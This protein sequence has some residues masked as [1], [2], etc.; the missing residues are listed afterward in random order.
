MSGRKR[1]YVAE[2]DWN[3]LQADARKLAQVNRD[4]PKLVDQLRTQTERDLAHS[5]AE[6]EA[7]HDRFET[8][9]TDLSDATRAAE[10][11]TARRLRDTSS[12]ILSRVRDQHARLRGETAAALRKDRETW[13]RELAD[14]RARRT[15][16]LAELDRKVTALAD[17]R[18]RAARLTE[19][20]L[21][22]AAILRAQVAEL[23]HERYLPGKLAELD[24]K[25]RS[26]QAD[27]D[28]GGLDAFLLANAR[29]FCQ[30]MGALRSELVLLDTEWRA[31][32]IAAETELL[33]L[34]GVI[35]GN[36]TL[37][38]EIIFET[39]EAVARPDVDYWS[40]GALKRLAAEVTTL[41][42]Q[43]RDD[44]LP[45]TTDALR[46]L[47]ASRVP[48]LDRRLDSVVEQAVTGLRS[49]QLR[50][51]LADLIADALDRRHHYQVVE[52]DVGY[53]D[54]DQR[55]AFLAKSANHVTGSEIVI[56]VAPGETDDRPPTVRLHNF[57][58]DVAEEERTVRTVSIHD[59]VLERTGIDLRSA[60][61]ASEP[62]VRVRDV[63]QLVRRKGMATEA[64]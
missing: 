35:E 8:A 16:Q 49:S 5:M 28:G 25:L 41:L 39:G 50:A 57:D 26:L 56:E 37:D 11:R 33:R 9:L 43:V 14:E 61:E 60:E 44:E 24:A 18:S 42:A 38:P 15:E 32:R 48:E 52:S 3:R 4:L 63:A 29:D 23:P 45:L 53:A 51:N 10:E 19:T 40:R 20:Y 30:E 59:S 1:I 2:A 27:R 13:Q 12:A 6:V 34:Q 55:G 21:N 54:A 22:D 36:A 64:V 7:R 46:E 17:D 62:D 58:G 47:L 31:C